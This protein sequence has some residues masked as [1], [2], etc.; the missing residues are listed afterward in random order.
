M[1]PGVAVHAIQRGNNRVD[2]FF[3]EEDRAFYL[4][5]LRR[6][7]PRARCRLHAYCLMTNHVHL[8][9]T[10]ETQSACA[11]LMKGIGQLH[12]QYI[13]KTYG[14]RGYLW[15]GRFK[16]CLVQSDDYLLRCHCY[17]D[18]N[19]V[20]AGVVRN[21]RDYPWSSYA[22]HAL[23]QNDSLLSPHDEYLG[24]GKEQHER[25]AAYRELLASLSEDQIG[26]IRAA[27]NAGFPLG[28][29]GFKRAVSRALGRRVERGP[30]AGQRRQERA[31]S[32]SIS[33]RN[34]GPSLI[35][36]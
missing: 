5:H 34:R 26:E 36:V 13:N 6:L 23:G 32:S 12:A 1:L 10:P 29:D 3:A 25:Q 19:P 22:A 11:L 20:R 2:C 28:S 16:S 27:T 17:I 8:L 31:T 21:A 15:E 30:P 4:F 24:L 9:L 18:L 7:L 14:H 33:F 35:S